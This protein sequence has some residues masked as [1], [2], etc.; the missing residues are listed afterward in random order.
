MNQE[1]YEILRLQLIRLYQTMEEHK[2]LAGKM[3][4]E[5]PPFS[6]EGRHPPLSTAKILPSMEENR[7]DLRIRDH[8]PLVYS[9]SPEIASRVRP[10]P[11]ATQAVTTMDFPSW[12]REVAAYKERRLHP[13]CGMRMRIHLQAFEETCVYFVAFRPADLEEGEPCHETEISASGM[14]FPTRLPHP[15]GAELLVVYFLP[16]DPFP[17]LQLVGETVRPSRPDAR[18]GFQTPLRFVELTEEDRQRI[19][20]YIVARQRRKNLLETYDLDG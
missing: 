15:E 5:P 11:P 9:E 7:R 8:V 19:L 2:A 17:P 6:S 1:R 3:L 10:D 14:S 18:G 20:S 13:P 16:M 4:R 12:V